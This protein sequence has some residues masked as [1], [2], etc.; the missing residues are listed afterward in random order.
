MFS[1]RSYERKK[2]ARRNEAVYAI[3]SF[4]VVARIDQLCERCE[5]LYLLFIYED[6][7]A[8][9]QDEGHDTSFSLIN[10]L[11]YGFG[12]WSFQYFQQIVA[13]AFLSLRSIDN[14]NK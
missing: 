10:W 9:S 14:N 7:N 1:F 13:C 11:R 3:K 6:A 8:N 12:H 5:D 4:V 2:S